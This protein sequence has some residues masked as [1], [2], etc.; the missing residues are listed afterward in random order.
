MASLYCILI[1]RIGWLSNLNKVP[2]YFMQIMVALRFLLG[3][4]EVA[5]FC[6]EISLVNVALISTLII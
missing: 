6:S 1:M 2:D 5:R 4:H 3:H